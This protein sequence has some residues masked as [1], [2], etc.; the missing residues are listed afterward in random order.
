MSSVPPHSQ[1]PVLVAA[2]AQHLV[3]LLLVF[4]DVNFTAPVVFLGDP[5]KFAGLKMGLGQDEK[6]V[7]VPEI[8]GQVP[9]LDQPRSQQTAR[10]HVVCE[11]G[12]VLEHCQ[13]QVA[14]AKQTGENT[15]AVKRVKLGSPKQLK[16][17]VLNRR[18]AER[19]RLIHGSPP[20][21]GRSGQEG[22]SP[23]WDI[24]PFQS[25]AS[26]VFSPK[27]S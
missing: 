13:P 18:V 27:G 9:E 14:V 1:K 5:G 15:L 17:N 10:F 21:E 3:D 6:R 4:I 12:S 22:I 24:S 23:Q 20:A 2:G 11:A 7:G 8:V 16:L 25:N 19:K 26:S